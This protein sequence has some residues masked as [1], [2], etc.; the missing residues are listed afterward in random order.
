MTV[1]TLV[2]IYNISF[3]NNFQG[4]STSSKC[5]ISFLQY[6]QLDT[7]ISQIYSWNEIQH[8]SDSSSV[9][10][11][12]FFTEHTAMVYVIQVCWHL[13]SRIRMELSSILILLA[14]FQQI[15]MTYTTAVGVQW[16]T[17]HD[18]Q[19][20][21]PKH[22]E[23]HSK[24][25]FEKSAHIVGFILRNIEEYSYHFLGFELKVWAERE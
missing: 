13:A 20:K 17:H 6:N 2:S 4:K 16:K 11:Q 19:R 14:S 24:N 3:M 1:L 9:Y 10:H 7:L 23:F 21:C 8:V 25:K 15:C 22:V 12:E 5:I 18:G